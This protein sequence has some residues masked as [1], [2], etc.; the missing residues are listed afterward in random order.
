MTVT[1]QPIVSTI[2]APPERPPQTIGGVLAVWLQNLGGGIGAAVGAALAARLL[3]ADGST[4]ANAALYV[5]GGIFA[6]LMFV[7][8]VIDEAMDGD[9]YLSMNAENAALA[10]ERD[11]ALADVVALS[12]RVRELESEIAVRDLSQQ[13]RFVTA[14]AAPADPVGRDA[15]DMVGV[16]FS[17]PEESARSA[18]RE[19]MAGRGWP[20]K[21][22]EDAYA[23]LVAARVIVPKGKQP[24]WVGS[25]EEAL[26]LLAVRSQNRLR[27]A[28]PA[29]AADPDDDGS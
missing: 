17:S 6:L 7:R 1:P 26:N 12:I 24:R 19:V 8:A 22:Y 29:A 11:D 20:R 21:R 23:E 18:S 10:Y 28:Q 9:A 13:G 16:Y 5:G 27:A 2:E 25:E 15:R 4:I 14:S 3:G